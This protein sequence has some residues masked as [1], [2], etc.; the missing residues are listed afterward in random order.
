MDLENREF[1]TCISRNLSNLQWT[2]TNEIVD[3]HLKDISE[4]REVNLWDLNVCYYVSAVTLLDSNGLLNQKGI[5]Q[6]EKPGWLIQAESKIDAIRKHLSRIDV[7]LKCKEKKQFTKRQ[8][9]IERQVRKRF[10][11]TTKENLEESKMKL[12]QS[13]K[14]ETEKMRRRKVIEERKK[15]NRK[16]STN[17]KSVYH[18][19]CIS[20]NLSNLQWTITNEIV[21]KHLKDISEMRE[22]N[23]WDL[24]VCYYV[25]AVTLLDS[26]G[27]LNQKGIKQREKPGWL[28]QAESK[29]DAI[30]KHLS[31]IDIVLKCKEKKQFTKRQINIERQVR[32]RFGRTTKENLE[33]SKMKLKQSLKCETEKMRRRKVIEERKKI[34]RK[35]STN[36]KSVYHEFRKKDD[37]QVKT[38]PSKEDL[39][40]Y[41]EGIWGNKI[42]HD[43]EAPCYC[44]ENYCKDAEPIQCKLDHELIEKLVKKMK[45][46][47]SPGRDLV[48]GHWIKQ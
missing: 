37:F 43:T 27:L 1:T 23:L 38:L 13:L 47:T 39:T 46:N 28:I 36:P 4:M 29:I 10:G 17:P 31:R 32:K 33:E 25:S 48:V 9:N 6:R 34:N 42:T 20:R 26:N 21:D 7:V 24:N 18:T 19:T 40:K 41:W 14:C 5:K 35:F 8:I 30:R 12:K 44:R 45:N 2:I 3:K 11:R 22:V 15:I 16:F